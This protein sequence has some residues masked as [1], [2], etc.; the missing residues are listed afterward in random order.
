MTSVIGQR[1]I[2]G[3]GSIIKNSYIF[4]DT[5]IGA[6][7]VIESSIIGAGVNVKDHTRVDRGC[8]L[9]DGVS[10]GPQAHLESFERLSKRRKLTE[11]VATDGEDDSDIEDAEN[12]KRYPHTFPT[13]SDLHSDKDPVTSILGA[14]SNAMIW[15]RPSAE[16]DEDLLDDR[17]HSKNQR[18]VRLGKHIH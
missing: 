4:D 16:N 9:G 8:L 13:R 17:E 6:G 2:I 10:V 15:P 1:C 12:S 7:C 14:D 5:T 18:L 3:A 11:G